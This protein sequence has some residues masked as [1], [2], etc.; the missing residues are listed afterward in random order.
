MFLTFIEIV[1]VFDDFS[2]I[3]DLGL[4]GGV[5]VIALVR[6]PFVFEY[7][8]DCS[9]VFLKP[10]MKLIVNKVKKSHGRNFEKKSQF[11]D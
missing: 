7:L 5:L 3:L 4:S 6:G 1:P 11:S 2:P 8:R 9:L 10:Y